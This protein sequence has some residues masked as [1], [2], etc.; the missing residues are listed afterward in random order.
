MPIPE[1]SIVY[2]NTERN[3]S[4]SRPRYIITSQDGPWYFLKKFAGTQLR[5]QSYKVHRNQLSYIPVPD[6]PVSCQPS[7]HHQDEEETTYDE[8]P[9]NTTASCTPPQPPSVPIPPAALT[10][11]PTPSVD[12]TTNVQSHIPDVGTSRP[13][14]QTRLPVRLHDYD[15][16]WTVTA[17]SLLV[18]W[19][20]FYHWYVF[21]RGIR[22]IY[23]VTVTYQR[24][25][26][27]VPTYAGKSF[28]AIVVWLFF[29]SIYT[30]KMTFLGLRISRRE[31]RRGKAS[32]H[33]YMYIIASII[34]AAYP[35]YLFMF[36]C[37]GQHLN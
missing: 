1:G 23:V 21:R 36:Y 5:N 13:K 16:S 27:F 30:T 18:C 2:I 6:S 7:R 35:P 28:F 12:H 29:V 26:L 34:A 31:R 33:L 32:R 4:Q 9:D 37:L 22:P 19:T 15:M 24:V 14:R 11:P 25:L 8:F 10:E 20:F 17:K 3:K